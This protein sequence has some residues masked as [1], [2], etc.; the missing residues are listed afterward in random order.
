MRE[1]TRNLITIWNVAPNRAEY[2]E[3]QLRLHFAEAWIYGY[4]DLI[5]VMSNAVKDRHVLAA[6]VRCGA[7]LIV[8][9]N[10][11]DFPA[12]SLEP[13]NVECQGPSTFLRNLY[14]LDP[15][16]FVHKLHQQASAIGQSLEWLLRRLQKNVPAF[17][18]YF[19]EEHEIRPEAN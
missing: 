19:C 2:P 8:T 1:V 11:R 15:A 7:E 12:A 4:E 5:P 10:A 9:Y 6:A 17:V 3:A 16:V 13:W 18:T 14:D